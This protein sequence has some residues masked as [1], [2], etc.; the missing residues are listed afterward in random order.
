[1]LN[2]KRTREFR[3]QCTSALHAVRIYETNHSMAAR[4]SSPSMETRDSAE[5][6]G[7]SGSA[8]FSAVA[9]GQRC[10]AGR[11]HPTAVNFETNRATKQEDTRHGIPN[12]PDDERQPCE[13]TKRTQQ[14]F[15]FSERFATGSQFRK[16]HPG[17]CI[18]ATPRKWQ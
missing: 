18:R 9:C 1:M 16:N 6:T 7:R 3:N 12:K 10:V 4:P 8:L 2:A 17:P 14:P 11:I 15:V 5:R 13:F